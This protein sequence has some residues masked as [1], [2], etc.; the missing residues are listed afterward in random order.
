M[1]SAGPAGGTR[2]T[3]NICTVWIVAARGFNIEQIT[4][5]YKSQKQ[6]CIILAYLDNSSFFGIS[7]GSKTEGAGRYTS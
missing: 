5:N 3:K 7:Y 1:V 6:C 2:A 4:G